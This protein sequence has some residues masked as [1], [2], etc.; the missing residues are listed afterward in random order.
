MRGGSGQDLSVADFAN[1]AKFVFS[2]PAWVVYGF[3][4]TTIGSKRRSHQLLLPA[5]ALPDEDERCRHS[6]NVGLQIF[7][8]WANLSWPRKTNFS[9]HQAVD[10]YYFCQSFC[11]ELYAYEVGWGRLWY[12]S[13]NFRKNCSM[14]LGKLQ[15]YR[16]AK[17]SYFFPHSG[18]KIRANWKFSRPP[19]K[20]RSPWPVL[21]WLELGTMICWRT[22]LHAVIQHSSASRLPTCLHQKKQDLVPE[23]AG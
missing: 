23:K 7:K 6:P 11:V 10:S 9:F 17:L 21:L 22:L 18:V 2:W 3:A 4:I 13:K 12:D 19:Q 15:N 5:G 1:H 20:Q 8:C 14:C 16:P